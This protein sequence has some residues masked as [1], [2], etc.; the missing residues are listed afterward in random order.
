MVSDDGRRSQVQSESDCR[1]DF[2]TELA[3]ESGKLRELLRLDAMAALPQA[4]PPGSGLLV[5]PFA[6]VPSWGPIGPCVLA[7]P[8]S[9][10]YGVGAR[11]DGWNLRVRL[12]KS[13]AG[14]MELGS[15]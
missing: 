5:T 13:D 3:L 12:G 8:R 4:G 10:R 11:S 9:S 15:D 2:A 1:S 14:L 7:R 6:R